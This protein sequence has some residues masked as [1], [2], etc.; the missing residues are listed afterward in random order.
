MSRTAKSLAPLGAMG[1]ILFVAIAANTQ[2]E[3]PSQE[4]PIP[5]EESLP[6][7]KAVWGSSSYIVRMSED[8]VIVYQGGVPG[9]RATK[10]GKG[11]RI[12]PNDPAVMNY[13]AYLDSRHD[14]ALAAVG[15]G[16]KL[17]DY[18]Y[19]LNGFAAQL[20]SEQAANLAV[21]PGVVAVE[22]DV[23][24]P[25]DTL[26]TPRFLGLTATG[27]LWDQLGGFDSAGEDVIIGDIDTGVWPEHPSLSDRTG[28]NP[29]GGEG[30]LD[31]HHIP[32]WHGKCVP[33]QD[34][35]ASNCNQKLIGCRFYV[36]GF[37][38]ENL[39]P[40][41]FLSCRDSDGHGTHTATTAA[42]NHGVTAVIDG[43][44]LG[45]V[46]GVAP[47]ARIAAYKTCWRAPGKAASCFGSDRAA[48]VDQ[49][50]ADGVDVLNHSAATSMTDFLDQVS[51]AFLFAAQSGVFVAASGGNVLPPF[52]FATVA[53]PGPWI[54]TVAASSHDRFFGGTVGLGNGSTFS[55][56]SLTAS[57]AMLPLVHSSSVG[58]ATD[59]TPTN[60]TPFATRI[61]RCFVGHLD[62][63][64]AAGKIVLCDWAFGIVPV[65]QS[66]AVQQA[67]G[68][69]MILRNVQLTPVVGADLLHHVPTVHVGSA[70]GAAIK[71]YIDSSSGT[72]TAKLTGNIP[73]TIA[74]PFL[75]SFS[76][77]GPS[78]AAGG[79]ILKPD[80]TAP[81]VDILAGVSPVG[82]RG[83]L[84]DFLSG[85]S[86]SAAHVAGLGALLKQRHPDWSP[87]MIKSA[88]MTTATRTLGGVP[89]PFGEGAG[90]VKPN[91]AVDP[92]L[93][94]DH[95]FGDWMAFICGTGQLTGCSSTIDPSDLNQASIAIG[96]LHGVQTV[97]RTVTNVGPRATYTVT[98]TA[99]P[100]IG[101]VVNPTTLTLS[102]G[103][104]ASY[105]V[106]FTRTGAA[107]A[108]F[109][110]GFQVGSL[111]WS[112][113]AGHVV[114]SPLAIRPVIL[115]VPAQVSG[116]GASGSVSFQ[117]KYGYSGPFL[118]TISRLVAATTQVGHVV[119]D[120]DD[121][122]NILNP[123]ATKGVTSHT[124]VITGCGLC[125]IALFDDQTDGN[126]D[127]DLYVYGPTLGGG[128]GLVGSSRGPTSTEEVNLI[129]P[130]PG[131]YTVFV[132]GLNTDGPDANYTLFSWIGGPPV[133]NLTVAAPTPVTAGGTGTITASWSGLS[134]ATKY[135]GVLT[136]RS[137]PFTVVPEL[138][139]TLL[140][141]DTP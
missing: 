76:P 97:T 38:A 125:R 47:R 21:A 135:L 41:E 10:P 61:A 66:L 25:L 86:M 120:P 16:R 55:G 39:D 13:A 131:T 28:T 48:A 44:V 113:G 93:V 27:G 84:F 71:A 15:G 31:Y 119:D 99:P 73:G 136:F 133:G 89:S 137:T 65:D 78:R 118:T 141:V 46:S 4:E 111:T 49:A 3:S 114:R 134:P 109:P 98:V 85:T 139:H 80:L 96:D 77:A 108:T 115:T 83:R 32:G 129:N 82:D 62:P 7:K 122:F 91:A 92:G 70:D 79:D 81:A 17:Y 20:T 72:A 23:G 18:R 34:F 2:E 35:N 50:V 45:E 22:P 110:N 102:T 130:I 123:T 5:Q 140:R 29:N 42:G 9:L 37:G 94:Y 64:K 60:R 68:A 104:S 95:G 112:D 26:T 103:E 74:A 40:T 124:L 116:T 90:H 19:A 43:I 12:D 11:K 52:Q 69:G 8:P 106:T 24:V 132:H 128:F 54:T 30:K 138:G 14:D 1:L 59:P 51:V 121:H 105:S 87:M 100:G 101:V 126:D 33:G 117:A 53:S 75:A 63:A 56:A 57:T 36:A 58:A 6:T 107:F 127:L 88:L 67:G